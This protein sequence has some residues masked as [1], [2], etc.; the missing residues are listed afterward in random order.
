M[1][2]KFRVLISDDM[3]SRAAEILGELDGIDVDVRAG[4]DAAELLSVIGDYNGLLV[5]S[6]TKVTAEV[7]AAADQLKVIG[8]AGI[9]VDNID[10]PAASRRGII[11]E[12]A[13]SG[14]SVTTA[15]HAICLLLSLARNIPQ[16]TASLKAGKWEKKKLSGHELLGK[17][18]GVIGLGNIGRIVAERG[19]GLQMNVVGYDPFIGQDAAARL[20][21]DLVSF[22]EL[23][24]R[25]DFIT[26]HTPL[27]NDT[28]GLIGAG[29]L[30]KMKPTALL[31]NAAR[32][33]IV[34]EEAL[35]D[36]LE[37]NQIAGVA[38]D[39]FEQEPPPKGHPLV[40]HPKVI[41]TP[42]LG[43][44][45]GEAQAKVAVEVA[46]QMA[47]FAE[48]GE[49]RNAINVAP[50]SG[51]VRGQLSPWQELSSRLGALVAQL[52][53]ADAGDAGFIDSLSV[54]VIGEASDIVSGATAC[55]SSVLEGLLGIF[56]DLP[57]NAVNAFI[58]ATDRGLEVSEIKRHKDRDLASAIAV[59][60]RRG[61]NTHFVKGTL[62]HIGD[63][64]EARLVQ[65]DDFIVEARPRGRLLVVRNND[66]PGVIGAVGTLL[67]KRGINVNS[68][69]VGTGS[70]P[71]VAMA[72]WNLDSDVDDS[73]ISEIRDGELILS[74]D[75][76]EL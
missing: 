35:I 7:I 66:Q 73:L 8:R 68:L 51:E 22:D 27:T 2:S 16:A 53:S 49:V 52:V 15:E 43:A 42:H 50:V 74:A 31:V 56:M 54:E 38:L 39:V 69:H 21:V 28:R 30:A 14:N 63:R 25:G 33:G 10:V 1:S 32:G 55:T 5:R 18:L 26:I 17:T 6:R 67:G 65:I 41:C 44:S 23:L 59:T 37:N 9:G 46:E 70:T 3:S 12:N 13:P 45:T 40:A 58:I 47:A 60:A 29:A 48:R 36:A 4:I 72:L 24:S 71:G 11:V 62:Y 61:T 20:G 75:V 19:R 57:V 76:V 64:V 34:D